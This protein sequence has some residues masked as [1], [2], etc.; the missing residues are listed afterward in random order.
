MDGGVF[1]YYFFRLLLLPNA[2]WS[3]SQPRRQETLSLSIRELN[4]PLML[5]A[6]RSPGDRRRGPPPP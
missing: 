4:L 2:R 5:V 1:F 3:T 6:C